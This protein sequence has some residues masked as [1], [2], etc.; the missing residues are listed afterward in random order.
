MSPE[1]DS[2]TGILYQTF[3]KELTPMLFKLFQKTEDEGMLF[4]FILS[5]ASHEYQ[6]QTNNTHTKKKITGQY[7]Q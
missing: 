6:N 3:K 2:F 7:H 4:K 5:L 1:V